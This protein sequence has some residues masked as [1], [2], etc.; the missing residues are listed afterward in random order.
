MT[1]HNLYLYGYFV[2]STNINNS[3]VYMQIPKDN[4]DYHRQ[5]LAERCCVDLKKIKVTNRFPKRPNSP[6]WVKS[7]RGPIL[8]FARTTQFENFTITDDRLHHFVRGIVDA[9]GEEFNDTYTFRVWKNHLKH[10]LKYVRTINLVDATTKVWGRD[11]DKINFTLTGYS[12]FLE[13]L[14]TD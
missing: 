6:L 11:S 2:A 8:Q 14:L 3:T 4:I 5:W 7:T 13:R 12:T 9:T 10:V 1:D